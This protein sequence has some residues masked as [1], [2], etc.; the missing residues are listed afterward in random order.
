MASPHSPLRG[1]TQT[2]VWN[3][4][5]ERIGMPLVIVI[6]VVVVVVVVRPGS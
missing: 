2:P 1:Y 3:P 6:V 4:E 5:S